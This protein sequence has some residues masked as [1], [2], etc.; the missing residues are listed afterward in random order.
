MSASWIAV[1]V[2]QWIVIAILCL[3]CAGILRY[4][5]IFRERMETAAP[6]TT[7]LSAGDR[8]PE[9]ALQRIGTGEP[10]EIPRGREIVLAFVSPTCGG[11]RALLGQVDGILQAGRRSGRV[12]LA[13]VVAGKDPAD[14]LSAWQRI[15]D[16]AHANVHV[17][18]DSGN[19][20]RGALGIWAVPAAMLIDE[21]GRVADQS[22]NPQ[23]AGWIYRALREERPVA[24]KGSPEPIPVHTPA[25]LDIET[26]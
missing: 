15:C 9:L 2:T 20:A 3:V 25:W 14:L 13:L 21:H 7:A 16:S 6:A 10:F 18:R 1:I 12:A 11:C 4:L 22:S 8:V 17:V 23:V 19:S 24:A 26:T 5:A